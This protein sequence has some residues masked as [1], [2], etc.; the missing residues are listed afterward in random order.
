MQRSQHPS[1]N[2][3]LGAPRGM[4]IDECNALPITRIQ[5]ADGTPAVASFWRP[6]AEELALINQGQCIRLVTLGT[7][8]PPLMLGVDGDGLI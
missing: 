7:T 4:T 5:Y 1:N 6:T 8:H 2:D 3:V